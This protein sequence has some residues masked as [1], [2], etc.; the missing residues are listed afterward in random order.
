MVVFE[1]LETVSHPNSGKQP[2]RKHF[3]S[4]I[5]CIFRSSNLKTNLCYDSV[6]VSLTK[7][8]GMLGAFESYVN[9]KCFLN[10]SKAK[11]VW[12]SLHASLR[13]ATSAEAKYLNFPFAF[14]HSNERTNAHISY[15]LFTA[16]IHSQINLRFYDI[17]KKVGESNENSVSDAR[18]LLIIE[19]LRK[20]SWS[21]VYEITLKIERCLTST[22]F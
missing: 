20:S 21:E 6:Y 18:P 9:L 3:H 15:V 1:R 13:S 19:Y 17:D 14:F 16:N 2:C 11:H 22:V 5:F 4:T 12:H 10:A 7:F 8:T